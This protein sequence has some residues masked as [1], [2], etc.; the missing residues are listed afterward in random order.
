[1][2]REEARECLARKL[3]IL[4]KI[5]ANT[6]TQGKFVGRREMRGLRRLL[7]ERAALIDELAAVD[8]RLAG[9]D[10]RRL[11]DASFAAELRAIDA[12]HREV[13]A[14]CS[15][16]ITQACAERGRI[17]AELTSSRQVRQAK[18]RYVDRW[19]VMAWGNRLNVKG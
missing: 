18:N 8:E 1:M 7:A 19:Q 14:A 10:T 3:A 16:V 4:E 9:D 15:Q 12:K 5:A 2:N 11:L 17:A 13:L 6:A